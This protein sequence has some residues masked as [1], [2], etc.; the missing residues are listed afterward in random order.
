MRT[1][2]EPHRRVDGGKYEAMSARP[3]DEITA[4]H[5]LDFRDPAWASTELRNRG[6]GAPTSLIGL[7][8]R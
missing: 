4:L 5:M 1:A 6:E 3:E 8:G 7:P 2:L